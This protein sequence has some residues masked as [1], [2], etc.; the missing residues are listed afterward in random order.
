MNKKLKKQLVTAALV[1][2]GLFLVFAVIS[3]VA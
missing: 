3:R 1:L 2:V